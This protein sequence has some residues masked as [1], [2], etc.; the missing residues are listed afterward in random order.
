MALSARDQ[1]ADALE[2]GDLHQAAELVKME[3]IDL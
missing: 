1:L 3:Q 2:N